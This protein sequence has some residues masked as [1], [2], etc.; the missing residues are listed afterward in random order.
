MWSLISPN[1]INIPNTHFLCYCAPFINA[2]HSE[3]KKWSCNCS[4]QCNTTYIASERTFFFFLSPSRG[5]L[6]KYLHV[7]SAIFY[8]NSYNS[9][10]M[11]E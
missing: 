3:E 9:A 7:L 10:V 2:L 5:C 11:S 1:E 8:Y 6:V 4:L